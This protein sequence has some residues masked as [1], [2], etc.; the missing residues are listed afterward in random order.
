MG[1]SVFW[2]EFEERLSALESKKFHDSK[3]KIEVLIV[4][5]QRNS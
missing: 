4:V 3:T 5:C 1:K 2:A